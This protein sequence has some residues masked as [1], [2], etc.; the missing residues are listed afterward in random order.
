M[1]LLIIDN[2][3]DF[4]RR[5]S[6]F[7][8]SGCSDIAITVGDEEAMDAAALQGAD[9]IIC[10]ENV[11]ENVISE[12]LGS[13]IRCT[14]LLGNDENISGNESS[15][16]NI[17]KYMFSAAAAI[18]DTAVK[19]DGVYKFQS[20]V[21]IINSIPEIRDQAA[22]LGLMPDLR[23]SMSVMCVSGMTG[24]CGRTSFALALARMLRQKTGEGV[25]MIGMSQMT[26]IYNYFT[27]TGIS[28]SADINLLLLN[29]ASGSR[30]NASAYLISDDYGV[31]CIR[32]P[33]DGMSDL[34]SLTAEEL[35]GFISYIRAWNIFGA[36][37]FDMDGR[38]DERSRYLYKNADIIYALHDDRRCPF[39]VEEIWREWLAHETKE[40]S[41]DGAGTGLGAERICRI[42]NFDMSGGAVNRIF[43]DEESLKTEK[44]Y[45]FCL[46]ADPDSFFVKNGR[47]DISMSGAFAAAVGHVYKELKKQ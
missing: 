13:G 24:G 38:F 9:H 2:D 12:V 19:A 15:P 1:R 37:I 45:D 27:D 47:A 40:E 26:D 4:R 36:V 29:Y 44:I 32:P 42:L 35:A 8:A 23:S 21:N 43:F 39:G 5:F 33:R 34:T 17:K 28:G 16:D 22:F 18:A 20:A 7:I 14:F 30:V 41:S 46:P 11:S 6:G 31:S 25:L 3:A 10:D